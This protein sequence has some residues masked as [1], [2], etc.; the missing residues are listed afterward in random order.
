MRNATITPSTKNALTNR[1]VDVGCRVRK[2]SAYHVQ[3]A[4]HLGVV[5]RFVA[6]GVQ[7]PP[8]CA[9]ARQQGGEAGDQDAGGFLFVSYGREHFEFCGSLWHTDKIL[10]SQFVVNPKYTRCVSMGSAAMQT[11][12]RQQLRTQETQARLLDAAEEIFVRDGYEAAQLDEIAARADRS[13][14]AVYTHFKSKEDLFL[15]LFEQ[16]TRSYVDRLISN[17]HRCKSRKQSMEAF[18]EFY[19]GLVTDR[20][21]PILTLEF[22]LFALRHPESKER[23]RRAFEMARPPRDEGNESRLFGRLTAQQKADNDLALAALGPIVSGLILESYFEPESLSEDGIRRI[24]GRIFD[25]LF[26]ASR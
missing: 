5:R 15:V 23:L 13:K 2:A 18:R 21:W 22:K 26:S 20:T 7:D 10:T 3:M 25:A 9:S 8:G 6:V 11:M 24:L 19:V 4:V 17:L 14:G 12:T 16:R 1:D